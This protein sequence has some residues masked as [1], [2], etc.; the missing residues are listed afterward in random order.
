MF[1]DGAP[2]H[3]FSSHPI[4]SIVQILFL[5]HPL[6]LSFHKFR[7]LTVNQKKM[8]TKEEKYTMLLLHC[9]SVNNF[10]CGH[11]RNS[12]ARKTTDLNEKAKRKRRANK[13]MQ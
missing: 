9:S 10:T 13:R 1:N 7:Y 12:R 5:S 6:S 3:L 4:E 8:K 11:K 2:P